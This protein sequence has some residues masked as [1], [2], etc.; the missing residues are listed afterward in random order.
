MDRPVA[1]LTGRLYVPADLVTDRHRRAYTY[2]FGP[3][4]SDDPDA[5]QEVRTYREFDGWV[6]FPRGDV[7]KLIDTFG[8]EFTIQDQRA[9]VPLDHDLQFT[10]NLRPDQVGVWDAWVQA[11][12][13]GIVVCPPRWGKAILGVWMVCQLR[14]KALVLAQEV[15]LLEQFD[16]KLRQFTNVDS[17]ERQAKRRLS[18]VIRKA[19]ERYDVVTLATWQQFHHHMDDLRAHRDAWGVVIVDEAHS[20]SAPCFSR[21][22]NTTNS[23][24]RIALTATPKR[25]DGLEVVMHDAVGQVTAVGKIEQ[26][27]VDVTVVSTGLVPPSCPSPNIQIRWNRLLAYLSQHVGRNRLIVSRVLADVQA[28]HR[29]LVVTDRIR[30]IRTL[31]GMLE[32]AQPG[33]KVSGLHGEVAGAKR[34]GLRLDA[35]AGDID[36][37]VAYSKIVQLGWDVWPWS[38]LHSTLP[39]ANPYNWYQ[40]ISRIRTKCPGCPGVRDPACLGESCQKK[41]PTC[42]IYV[43]ESRM[44]RNCLKVQQGEHERLGFREHHVSVNV[45]RRQKTEKP[46]ST[47]RTLRWDELTI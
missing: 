28:G 44:S 24:Y 30:H 46:R 35:A 12:R 13:R 15:S 18:G 38:S 27:P 16:E 23:R 37:V 6:G 42:T 11:G 7:P 1:I 41:R 19:D 31:I 47:G 40:R 10:G 21:V 33:L 20:A 43:D 22:I 32:D 36:V 26:L 8:D 4:A 3:E 25:K 45:R 2:W 34:R 5:F 17:L 39:M 29:V 14:Q 9:K